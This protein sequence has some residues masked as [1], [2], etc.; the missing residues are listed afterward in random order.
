LQSRIEQRSGALALA[1]CALLWAASASAEVTEPNG[2]A[3]PLNSANGETQLSTLFTDRSEAIDFIADGQATPDT[4]SPLCGFQATFVLKQ[5][6][7][8]LGVGWYNADPARTTPPGAAEIFEIVPA[9]TAVGTV[10]TGAEIRG[11]ANYLGGSIGFALMRSPAYFTESRYSPVCTFCSTPGPWVLSVS[12]QSTQTTNAYYVAFE[13]GNVDEFSWSNDGDF[14]DY[15]FFFEGL[16]CIG[17]GEACEVEG[18][19]GVCVPGVQECDAGGVL[20]CKASVEASDEVCDALDNDC[21]GASDEGGALCGESEVCSRGQC[22][23]PCGDSE[24]KCSVAPFTACEDGVCVEPECV[25]K[26]CEEGKACLGG[27]CV[28]PCDGVSCPLGLV[29]RVGTCVDPCEGVSCDG[30]RVC[31][32][33][34]CIL[35]CTCAGCGDGLACDERAGL[36]VAEGCETQTCG[37]GEACEAGA[38]VDACRG[39]SCPGGS[40]CVLGACEAIAPTDGGMPEPDAGG[41]NMPVP[42]SLPGADSGM[43]GGGNGGS[44][45]PTIAPSGVRTEMEA[46][47]CGCR[48]EAKRSQPVEN[49]SWVAMAISAIALI[50]LRRRARV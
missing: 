21:D 12:Y 4:F 8:S 15:V 5:S 41:T 18:A 40:T 11:S 6:G 36:C 38:C 45:A 28:A 14:N 44:M 10:I 20:V 39:A 31:S 29:C 42:P 46:A 13:D 16:S 7:S 19:K 17:E 47:G 1:A 49:I 34:A 33:G 35:S 3:V 37:A 48:I 24:F 27:E 50:C 2:V 22:V 25:G 26:T 43:Q 23:K 32:L 30:E 9:G